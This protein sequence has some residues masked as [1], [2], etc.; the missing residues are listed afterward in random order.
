MSSVIIVGCGIGGAACGALLAKANFKTI[1]LEKNKAVGGKASTYIKDGFVVESGVHMFSRCE[2]GPHGQVLKELEAEESVKWI[3]RDPA[4]E[5]KYANKIFRMPLYFSRPKNIGRFL[6]FLGP[7]SGEM[8]KLFE[9]FTAMFSISESEIK[10][11]DGMDLKAWLSSYTDNL[12]VHDFLNSVCMLYF[13]LPY[14]RASAGE[15]IYCFR[16][17]FLDSS[18]GYVKGG[19]ASISKAFVESAGKYGAE[20]KTGAPV[21][22]ILVEDGNVVGVERV[23]GE[24]IESK[25]VISNAGIRKTVLKLAGEKHFSN[26]Y[27]NYVKSLKDSLGYLVM[28]IALKGAVTNQPCHVVMPENSEESFK[29]VDAGR[30]PRD[31]FLFIPIPSNLD[32]KLA[33]PGH[34]LLTIG[35]PCPEDPNI[36][37]HPWITLL[38]NKIEEVFPNIFDKALWVE[39]TTPK[40]VANWTGSFKG[41]TIGLAQTPDQAGGNRPSAISPIKGLYYV[42]AD[43]RGRGIGTELAVDSA[44]KL[45]SHLI[46]RA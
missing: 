38:R 6:D 29:E 41:S 2:K 16:N 22:R 18:F 33:P 37:F 46:A 34:Q 19:S 26:E 13:A 44:L 8:D 14:Y 4:T 39:V 30:P 40:D 20:I 9:M 15:F 25:L 36:N 43:V 10:N 31:T 23:D 17:M 7:T 27:V 35:T 42:G 21:K 28:K 32:P 3:Y 24:V 45:S 5:I 1:I 12:A 11:Y